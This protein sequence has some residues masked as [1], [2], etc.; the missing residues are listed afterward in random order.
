MPVRRDKELHL[1]AEQQQCPPSRKSTTLALTD[2][3]TAVLAIP[4]LPY[5]TCYWNEADIA[6]CRSTHRMLELESEETKQCLILKG[7][8][9]ECAA[10]AQ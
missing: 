5:L 8:I 4:L 6:L 9:N 10:A 2:V 3:L 7:V 1:V